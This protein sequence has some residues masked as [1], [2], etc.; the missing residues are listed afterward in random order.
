MKPRRIRP[1]GPRTVR[2]I[3]LAVSAGMVATL[4]Q[5]SATPVS[6]IAATDLPGLPAS[7]K[8]VESER[9][10]EVKPRAADK[11]PQAPVAAPQA[12]LPAPSTATIAVPTS[13]AEGTVRFV[14]PKGQPIGIG[15]TAPSAGSAQKGSDGA[16]S[17]RTV[18]ATPT[19]VTSRILDR[20]QATR[21][22]VNGLLF[23]LAS[24]APA[25]VDRAVHSRVEAPV[26]LSVD[27]AAF[28][29]SYGGS[30]AS[31]MRLI[32]LPSCALSTPEREECREGTPVDATN[33]T[34]AQT[35]TADAVTLRA[36]TT[37]VLAA[38]A[39]ATGDKGDYKATSLSPSSSWNTSLNTGDF[40]W[41]YGFQVPEVPGSL[42]PRLGL[43]YSSGSI[44][45]RS[46]GTNNQ[47]SWAGDGF[48]LWPGFIERRYKPCADDGVKNADGNKPGD[49]CWAYD[50]AFISFNGSSGELI[51]V[52]KDEFKLK[53]DDGTR[54][55]RLKSA[56]R[57]NGDNDNEYWRLTSPDGIQ[58]F[59]GYNRLPGWTTGKPTTDSTWTL[60]VYGN[61]TGEECH[62]ATFADSW[63]Q[64]AW[65]W[66]VDYV[67]DPHGNAMSYHY[68]KETNSYGRN[69]KATD[70]TPYTR[71]GTLKRIDYGQRSND[72]YTAKPLSQ[73]VFASAE[74]CLPQAGVTC[75]ADTIDTNAFHWYDTPWDLNCK[76]GTSCDNGRLSPSFWT[77]KRLTDITTQV[78]KPDG[79]Y[80]KVDSWKLAH[81]WGMADTDYQL[82]LTSIQHTGE[83]A[84][85]T[86]TGEPAAPAVTLPKTTFAYTQLANRLDRTG[87]GFAPFIKERLH[88]VD[89]ESGGQISANYSAPACNWNSLPTPE[90]NTT[91]CF[92]QYIGGNDTDPATEQWFN[93]YVTTSVTRTD[94]TGGSPDQVTSY[95]YL[96][97]AAWHY[98][99]DDGLT[100]EKEKTWSQWR[101]YGQVRV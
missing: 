4:L 83:S 7:E 23:T 5:A 71:G 78:L 82:L 29:E 72:L 31:R 69:L 62:G 46:G 84:T 77:R 21:A 41:S 65:R 1:S 44:D 68:T 34:A 20:K 58:Y 15:R 43:S 67:V 13:V 63:C 87:D 6:A 54:I 66:N 12:T 85:P 61:N 101:G 56:D 70:D 9:I 18:P 11:G 17:A 90:T 73:V 30:Y 2:R 28:A 19:N 26:T 53:R 59:F 57:A 27:Y 42:K 3:S 50:N 94:R 74:R 91:R 33:D 92:P 96:G 39:A 81:R 80:G 16:R 79:S 52:S 55:T 10:N 47:G 97:D 48:D 95:Q 49:M 86:L 88:A 76:A 35:L 22:G 40:N 45:G 98:N 25:A 89:D 36:G 64:Q 37:T 8:S 99:D 100:K 51:P 38:T 32:E 14:R 24:Q 60:P 75:A 93:K